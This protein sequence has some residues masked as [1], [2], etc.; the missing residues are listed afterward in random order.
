MMPLLIHL[1][2]LLTLRKARS[3]A[4]YEY[5][6]V[7]VKESDHVTCHIGRYG[8]TVSALV[9]YLLVS[10]SHRDC[11]DFI[12][13]TQGCISRHPKGVGVITSPNNAGVAVPSSQ[14]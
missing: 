2:S 11:F 6:D 8:Q 14:R 5:L 4:R 13:V 7:A 10:S 9:Q 12:A 3:I 1:V